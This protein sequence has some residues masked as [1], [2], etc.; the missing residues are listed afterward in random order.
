MGKLRIGASSYLFLALFGACVIT[1][2]NHHDSQSVP[3]PVPEEIEVSFSETGGS[4]AL[5]A[6]ATL[7]ELQD[8]AR[9]I[10]VYTVERLDGR[11]EA[12][13]DEDFEL[14]VTYVGVMAV[15]RWDD[16]IVETLRIIGGP[17]PDDVLR[18]HFV[19]LE[20]GKTYVLFP[21]EPF[22]AGTNF[23]NLTSQDIFEISADQKVSNGAIETDLATLRNA[24]AAN[25]DQCI[26]DMAP[27]APEP[28]DSPDTQVVGEEFALEE[29]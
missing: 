28:N 1:A 22:A 29:E 12:H 6:P 4:H 24:V 23:R 10:G 25:A 8:R 3:R 26:V 18:A 2:C 9:G 27:A 15:E 5:F 13:G 17:E 7:C 16:E 14:G 20:V 19:E 21:T 11:Y